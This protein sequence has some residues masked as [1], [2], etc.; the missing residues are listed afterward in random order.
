MADCD[1]TTTEPKAL[2]PVDEA[3]QFLLS[4]AK[5]ITDTEILP[6]A[7][8]LGRVLAEPVKSCVNVPPWNN[9]AMDGYA[10][11]Y[12]EVDEGQACLLYTS[13]AADE[14]RAG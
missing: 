6:C 8:A 12:A 1:C 14:L 5:A 7:D 11:S 4:H 13:D 10:F 2:K 3:L 9:S